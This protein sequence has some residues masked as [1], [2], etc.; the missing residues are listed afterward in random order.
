LEILNLKFLQENPENIKNDIK[1][2][3][4]KLENNYKLLK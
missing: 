2:T 4:E 3:N 1:L